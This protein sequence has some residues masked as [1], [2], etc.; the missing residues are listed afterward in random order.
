MIL[1][2]TPINAKLLVMTLFQIGS[3]APSHKI[4]KKRV[5]LN[6]MIRNYVIHHDTPERVCLGDLDKVFQYHSVSDINERDLIW[7]DEVH[8]TPTG[9][10]QMATV[11]FEAMKGKLAL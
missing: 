9:Y 10:D 8:L 2:R 3:Y 11:I 5:A 6:D 1:H 4:D 7:N